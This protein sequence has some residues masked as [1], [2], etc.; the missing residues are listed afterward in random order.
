[1]GNNFNSKQ[2]R[3]STKR[4]HY[5]NFTSHEIKNDLKIPTVRQITHSYTSILIVGDFFNLPI[6]TQIRVQVHIYKTSLYG[7]YCLDS[8]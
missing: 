7:N 2:G 5:S 6:F 8:A 1:M 4:V 3:S